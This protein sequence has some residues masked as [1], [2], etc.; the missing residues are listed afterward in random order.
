MNLEPRSTEKSDIFISSVDYISPDSGLT[1]SLSITLMLYL[2]CECFL[3]FK[4]SILML[5]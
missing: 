2:Y 4:V 3:V 1:L 5:F